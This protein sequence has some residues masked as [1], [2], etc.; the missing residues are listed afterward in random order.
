[1]VCRLA[2]HAFADFFLYTSKSYQF[3]QKKRIITSLVLW[4][5][6]SI[7]IRTQ[8]IKYIKYIH[9]KSAQSIRGRGI[10]AF[11]RTASLVLDVGRR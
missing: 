3:V 8:V 1:M 11:A 6:Y 10:A 2:A 7:I 4:W 9:T 5:F